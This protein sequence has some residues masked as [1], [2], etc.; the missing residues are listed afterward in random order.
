[1]QRAFRWLSIPLAF[2]LG[3]VCAEGG[4]APS[5]EESPAARGYRLLRTKPYLSG[6][7]KKEYFE[8]IW[9]V[10]P[11]ELAEKAAKATPQE[12]RRLVFDRY[13]IHEAPDS[14]NDGGLGYL[15]NEDGHLVMNCLSCHGGS[16]A[17]KVI[18]GLGNSHL[19]LQTLFD[20]TIRMRRRA[21]E[22][23][24]ASVMGAALTP[25]GYSNGTTNAQIFSVALV[26]LRDKDL[27]FKPP[28]SL[29]TFL[30]HDLDAPPLWNTKRKKRLYI[31]GFVEKTPRVIMQF[32]LEAPNSGERVRS[33]EK[34]F[35]DILAWIESLEA[36]KY[37]WNVDATLAAEGKGVFN[38]DCSRCHGTYG[39][40]GKYPE[41][42]IAIEELGVDRLRLDGM[43]V[44]HRRFFHTSW[45]GEY[46]A[47]AVVESPIGY[48][49]PPLDGIWASAPYF[50]NG[51][52]P[53]LWHLLNPE[54][55]P[56]VWKRTRDGYDQKRVG[57]ECETFAEIPS[58]VV[59]PDEKRLYF[60]SRLRGKS[61]AGHD[62]P[63][64]L[65]N[66]EKRA[67]LEYLKTL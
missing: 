12:R 3:P 48:V 28:K 4:A 39:P 19:A 54:E 34:E 20:D 66:G 63:A 49:A 22:N 5:A 6:E 29:P 35:V 60:N 18:P 33:W 7:L 11:A 14:L 17:G 27:N 51:S 45:F 2:A 57:L 21:K 64:S 37:P 10:W 8:R 32:V 30:H 46:G 1:M 24:A 16:V 43:P 40:G 23:V 41:K 52:V 9:E 36:P 61:A 44:E 59:R 65:S 38:R 26:M 25:F 50:H 13:G 53:T 15:I 56:V 31:D 55:R 42:T 62:Y 58:F 47:R 67:L